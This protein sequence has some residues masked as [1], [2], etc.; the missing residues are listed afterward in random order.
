MKRAWIVVFLFTLAVINYMDR[1][2]L[3]VASQPIA[4]EFGLSP[5]DLGFLFSAF[6]WTYLLCLL[7]IGALVDKVGPKTVNAVG[8]GLWSLATVATGLSW[9]YA[10]LVGTRLA[11]GAG[12]ATTF[13]AG[14]R[15]IRQW[16]PASERGI[17]NAIFNN[18]AFA[19]PAFGA[20]FVAWLVTQFGWRSSF[21]I[22]GAIGFVW[23]VAWMIWYNIPEK[24][25]WLGEDERRTILNERDGGL[26]AP[27]IAQPA[28]FLDLLRC[29][30]Q[31]GVTL[32]QSCIVYTQ[33]LFLTWLPGYLQQTKGLTVMSA[34]LYTAVPYGLAVLL[35]IALGYVS[36]RMLSGGQLQQG[37]RRTM[38]VCSLLVSSVILL[39]PFVDNIWIILGLITVTLT[40]LST[41]GAMNFALLNDLLAE[42][43]H[44]GKSMSIVIVGGNSFGVLAPIITGFVVAGTGSFNWAFGIAG[45]LLVS[46]ATIALT[47]T[48]TPIVPSA[49]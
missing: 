47:L 20:I 46:G 17:T 26:K 22:V 28:G 23:L 2:A 4:K 35:S 27:S 44:I 21:V 39:A 43:A 34:G 31:W 11:M 36:D 29:R 5:V 42:P 8:I 45:L 14:A 7:P 10:S 25:T 33:Y 38:I 18:G 1:V 9:S 48:R 32:T 41:A 13:P 19:G 15:V 24:A 49:R 37:G 30:S 6:L 12:E 40:G 3:S 16:I